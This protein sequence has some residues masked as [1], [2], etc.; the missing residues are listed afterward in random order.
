MTTIGD[1]VKK[2]EDI[3]RC[4]KLAEVLAY[5]FNSEDNK[6]SFDQYWEN[7]KDNFIFRNINKSD[8]D[9]NELRR[10]SLLLDEYIEMLKKITVDKS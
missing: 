1:Y 7:N 8:L 10:I 6:E 3:N 5:Y 2:L 9:T 4:R